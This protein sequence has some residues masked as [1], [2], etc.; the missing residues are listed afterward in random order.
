[1]RLTPRL[2]GHLNR[3]FSADPEPF[4]ALRLRYAGEM[5]WRVADG[6]LRTTVPEAPTANLDL[7]LAG[8]TIGGLAAHLAAQPG[9][10]VPYVALGEQARLSA[11]ALLDGEGDPARS[12][13]DHLRAYSSVLWSYMEA[14]AIELAA[15][16]AAIESLPLEMQTTTAEGTWLDLLGSYYGIRRQG[17]EAD[18]AYGARIIAEVLRPRGNNVAIEMAIRS[19][20]GQEAA[21]VD[22]VEWGADAPLHDGSITYDGTHL[23]NSSAQPRYGLFDITVGY[24]LEGAYDP[25]AFAASMRALVERL[26]DAGTQL[27]AVSLEAAEMEDSAAALLPKENEGVFTVTRHL[28]HN[29]TL[30]HDGSVTHSSTIVTTGPI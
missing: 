18:R 19:M 29:G 20:T 8:Y 17:G 22:V 15:A 30:T 28:T 21:V 12:N 4:L 14:L 9:Y 10:L 7:D 5:T 1:M 16:A 26:R 6:R 3:V 24:D 13:G 11:L 25:T 2:L 27:R 23:H